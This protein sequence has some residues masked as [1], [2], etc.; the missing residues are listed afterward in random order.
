M[1]AG[2]SQQI[3]MGPVL[4]ELHDRETGQTVRR[5]CRE[6]DAIG[7]LDV[8]K[9][10]LCGPGGRQACFDE[11]SRQRGDRVRVAG[12]SQLQTVSVHLRC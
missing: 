1:G 10:A 8:A 3:Q 4:A 11:L 7:T 12:R 9:Y 5:V 2:D 6:D